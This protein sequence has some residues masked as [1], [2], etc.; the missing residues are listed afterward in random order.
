MKQRNSSFLNAQDTRKTVNISEPLWLGGSECSLIIINKVIWVA[1]G[2]YAVITIID[3][4]KFRELS[5][6]S[7]KIK[8]K[9]V[10]QTNKPNKK[11]LHIPGTILCLSHMVQL[12]IPTFNDQCITA[13]NSWNTCLSILRTCLNSF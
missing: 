7:H 13:W 1:L 9:H 10:Q 6:K 4:L 3:R 11:A 2:P 8:S 5:G 12:Q